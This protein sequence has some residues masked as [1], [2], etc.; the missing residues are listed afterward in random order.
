MKGEHKAATLSNVIDECNYYLLP[1]MRVA[2]FAM[3]FFLFDNG[4]FYTPRA[5]L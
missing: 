3:D 5:S 2:E 4:Y 1:Q